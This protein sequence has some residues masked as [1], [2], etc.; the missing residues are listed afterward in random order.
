MT[1]EANMS[2]SSESL[3]VAPPVDVVRPRTSKERIANAGIALMATVGVG[4][5]VYV[6]LD[7][8]DVGPEVNA[9]VALA[10]ASIIAAGFFKYLRR[11]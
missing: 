4:G 8:F 7:Q 9:P 10:S 3:P 2:A 1:I 5:S 11:Y 6:V